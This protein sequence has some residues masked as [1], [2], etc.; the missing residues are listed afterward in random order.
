MSEIA[1]SGYYGFSNAGDEAMLA[2]M[3]EV[4]GDLAPEAIITVI[5]GNPDD[6]RRRHGVQ[7]VHR[8][9]V[10]AVMRLL[11]RSKLLISGGG[12]LLQDV[13]SERSLYYYLGV[14]SGQTHGYA[15]Y[16]VFAGNWAGLRLLGAASYALRRQ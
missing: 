3:I 13:T 15:G 7:A 2:A 1:I 16:V 12:S 5:S 6:T 14:M 4:I 11:K 8:L 10:P 9:D